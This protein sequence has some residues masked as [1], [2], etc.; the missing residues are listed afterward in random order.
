MLRKIFLAWALYFSQNPTHTPNLQNPTTFIKPLQLFYCSTRSSSPKS[1]QVET[2]F[3]NLNSLRNLN[4]KSPDHQFHI[5]HLPLPLP[6]PSR[7]LI[8]QWPL[9]LPSL[10]LT[11]PLLIQ[12][13]HQENILPPLHLPRYHLM[14]LLR[15]SGDHYAAFSCEMRKRDHRSNAKSKLQAEQNKGKRRKLRQRTGVLPGA[16]ESTKL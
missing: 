16:S 13:L 12:I 7:I 5:P 4:P 8:N 6:H 9:V 1:P 15:C 3:L 2:N 11:L 10:L 14:M